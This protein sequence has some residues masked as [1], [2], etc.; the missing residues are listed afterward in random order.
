MAFE[1]RNTGL[2]NSLTMSRICPKCSFNSTEKERSSITHSFEIEEAGKGTYRLVG[3]EGKERSVNHRPCGSEGEAS[4]Q[5]GV[6][7]RKITERKAG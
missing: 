6:F 3:R 5:P 7:L 4:E 1:L 2:V